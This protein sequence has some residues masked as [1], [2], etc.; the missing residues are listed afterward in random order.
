[1]KLVL[2]V[3]DF[4]FADLFCLLYNIAIHYYFGICVKT[5]WIFA[6]NTTYAVLLFVQGKMFCYLSQS[7]GSNL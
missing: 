3:T 2:P 5:Y 4:L 7:S 6:P 1:M